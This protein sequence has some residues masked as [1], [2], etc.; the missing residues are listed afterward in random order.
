MGRGG[1]GA[2]EEK[3]EGEIKGQ[4]RWERQRKGEKKEKRK[5]KED[6]RSV[7]RTLALLTG[8]CPERDCLQLA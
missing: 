7:L 8:W 1:E 2:I 3:R 6:A 4:C 5:K